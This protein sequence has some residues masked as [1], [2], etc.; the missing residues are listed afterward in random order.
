MTG[1]N[2][3]QTNPAVPPQAV[4]VGPPSADPPSGSGQEGGYQSSQNRQPDWLVGKVIDGKYRIV[5]RIGQGGL[6][7]VYK[8]EH[9]LMQRT[10]AFK[11]LR[12]NVANNP[13]AVVRFLRE[14]QVAS[15]FKH[16]HAIEVYDFSQLEDGTYYCAMEFL[17][18]RSLYD[19]LKVRKTMRLP[20][21]LEVMAQVL[22]A[23]TAAHNG[24]VVH[25]DLKPDNIFLYRRKGFALFAKLI[26]FGIAKLQGEQDDSL[27][28]ARPQVDN[29]LAPNVTQAGTFIGTPQYASPEQCRGMQ[30]DERSDLYSLGV[31]FYEIL[32]GELPFTSETPHGFIAQHLVQPVR[33]LSALKPDLNLPPEIDEVLQRALAKRP[34]E[35]YQS[36][37]EMLTHLQDIAHAMGI[38]L[39][40]NLGSDGLDPRSAQ[41][42]VAKFRSSSA[43]GDR[44]SY[45]APKPKR[46]IPWGFALGVT[47]ALAIAI[48]A[49][50]AYQSTLESPSASSSANRHLATSDQPET[51]G[52][53]RLGPD[54][55]DSTRRFETGSSYRDRDRNADRDG[56][57]RSAETTSNASSTRY[58]SSH[59]GRR[60]NSQAGTRYTPYGSR[61]AT[62]APQTSRVSLPGYGTAQAFRFNRSS[63]SGLLGSH[64]MAVNSSHIAMAWCERTGASTSFVLQGAHWAIAQGSERPQRD[65][66]I[67]PQQGADDWHP[68][69]ALASG[70]GLAV[71]VWERWSPAT[72]I[73][74]VTMNEEEASAPSPA[75]KVN[76]LDYGDHMDPVVAAIPDGRFAVAWLSWQQFSAGYDV[77]LQRYQP[78]ARRNGDPERL[79]TNAV[80][81]TRRPR[82]LQ[83]LLESEEYGHPSLD[84]ATLGRQWIV[85]WIEHL[86]G[87]KWNLQWRIVSDQEV[88]RSGSHRFEHLLANEPPSL[89]VAGSDSGKA[90]IV[91]QAATTEQTQSGLGVFALTINEVSDGT[92]ASVIEVSEAEGTAAN[93]QPV[94]AMDAKGTLV[95]AWEHEPLTNQAPT[96]Q[97]HMQLFH[98][99]GRRIGSRQ[100]LSGAGGSSLL[101]PKVVMTDAGHIGVSWLSLAQGEQNDLKGR[102]EGLILTKAGR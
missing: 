15:R 85:A 52:D 21:A 49:F 23:L 94:C 45:A 97:I 67:E 93:L 70:T 74:C 24:G 50:V 63:R 61:S 27:E 55:R 102:V 73:M 54:G 82:Q 69:I 77:I 53:Y 75:F 34:E 29:A 83:S 11:T 9:V 84:I 56:R 58:G 66:L 37:L 35:R 13:A 2:P 59:L 65:R 16:P 31:V 51:G 71:A 30:I 38:H 46:R 86:G 87:T 1:Q 92:P 96:T 47:T 62:T 100:R 48:G 60:P 22:S 39:R 18:G 98:N 101:F 17:V 72:S 68:S 76:Q 10:C 81:L 80:G 28:V 14:G 99:S 19:H 64:A 91:W 89:A 8:A 5:E 12:A 36:A 26:D 40:G 33:T 32:S 79:S 3:D 57:E 25:R 7:D 44:A 41:L 6:G 20:E 90:A 4:G 43:S 88:G 95:V 78:N 42:H